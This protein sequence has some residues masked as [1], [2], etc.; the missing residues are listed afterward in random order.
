MRLFAKYPDVVAGEVGAKVY[1]SDASKVVVRGRVRMVP[2]QDT[3]YAEGMVVIEGRRLKSTAVITAEVNER[4]ALA[5]VKVD[6][7]EEQGVRIDFEIRD[8]DFGNFRAMWA[9]H[10]RKPNL[11]LISGRHKSLCRY[12][13]DPDK[14]FS[15]AE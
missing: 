4:T 8:E 9:N 10:E 3:N 11:L 13:G 1:S 15:W 5:T 7:P 12:L 6:K 2:I 14:K